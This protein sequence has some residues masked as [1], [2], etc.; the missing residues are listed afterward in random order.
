[1]LV[2]DESISGRNLLLL[3]E[4]AR[5]RERVDESRSVALSLS[6]RTHTACVGGCEPIA[7]LTAR[8]ASR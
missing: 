6:H 7:P 3:R 5:R 4:H 2:L 8:R 1:M